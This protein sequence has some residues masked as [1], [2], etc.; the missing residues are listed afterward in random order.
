MLIPTVPQWFILVSA[1]KLSHTWG[2][3]AFG[4]GITHFRNFF[5]GYYS[6]RAK[7]YGV[8]LTSTYI[9][10]TKF[11]YGVSLTFTYIFLS[12]KNYVSIIFRFLYFFVF[13]IKKTLL[14]H[15]N[16]VPVKYRDL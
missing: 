15:V 8:L 13:F 1:H 3:F 16:I 14:V 6:F 11:F 9:F 2:W 5:M 4:W 12:D 10:S 7:F